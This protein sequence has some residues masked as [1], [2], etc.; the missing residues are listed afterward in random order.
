MIRV[1]GAVGVRFVIVIE[2]AFVVYNVVVYYSYK[3]PKIR[4]P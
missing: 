4:Y 1:R 3:D 2:M